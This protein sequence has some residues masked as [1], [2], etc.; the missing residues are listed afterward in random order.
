MDHVKYM[1]ENI[2]KLCTKDTLILYRAISSLKNR[3]REFI[4]YRYVRKATYKRMEVILGIS[5]AT[6]KR[7][8]KR[9]LRSLTIAV[10]GVEK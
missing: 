1:L 9:A 8:N 10:F 5:E 6:L 3:E 4:Y 2:D 7:I